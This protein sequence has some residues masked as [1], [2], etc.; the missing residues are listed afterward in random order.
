MVLRSRQ[1]VPVLALLMLVGLP[2]WSDV[3]YV[4]N[5]TTLGGTEGGKGGVTEMTVSIAG[6]KRR[7]EAVLKQGTAPEGITEIVLL[8]EGL[9]YE[10]DPASRSY[11]EETFAERRDR[12]ERSSRAG[13]EGSR[14]KNVTVQVEPTGAEKTFIVRHPDAGELDCEQVVI[15]VG[16]TLENLD[17]REWEAL[18]LRGEVWVARS[19]PGK[20]ELRSFRERYEKGLGSTPLP[21]GPGRYAK[22]KYDPAMREFWKELTKLGGLPVSLEV[23]VTVQ[24]E[25]ERDQLV[26]E[27]GRA[28]SDEEGEAGTTLL[29][30]SAGRKYR[31]R[32]EVTG[33][34]PAS[35]GGAGPEWMMIRKLVGVREEVVLPGLFEPPEGYTKRVPRSRKRQQKAPASG[36]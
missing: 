33:Q 22:T 32:S 24:R 26:P 10:I 30:T 23:G 12:L 13:G 20:S 31:L 18:E 6:A 15:T 9:I 5:L 14:F 1:A 11:T 8:D 21:M 16:G 17:S 36:P 27:V 25:E 19:F 29:Q 35:T 34:L 7:T 2:A 3:T 28:G 4:E